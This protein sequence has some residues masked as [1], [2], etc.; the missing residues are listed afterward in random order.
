MD[1]DG[2]DG[3]D[4]LPVALGQRAQEQGDEVVQLGDLLLVVVLYGILVAL[5]LRLD[6]GLL[7][8]DIIVYDLRKRTNLQFA[9][10][11]PN[12]C[13]PP[14]LGAAQRDLCGIVKQPLVSRLVLVRRHGIGHVVP[15]HKKA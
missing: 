5:L 1:V 9:K 13:R 6:K 4:L 3:H 12:L 10:G 8:E 2:A 14:D 11:D 15:V 7:H